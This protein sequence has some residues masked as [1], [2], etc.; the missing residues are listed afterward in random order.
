MG[1]SCHM[2]HYANEIARKD[3]EIANLRK[4]K[5]TAETS[6]RK[7]IHDKVTAQ[8]E[9]NDKIAALE[10]QVDRYAIFNANLNRSV[11]NCIFILGSNVVKPEK[12][13]IWSI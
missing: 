4:S 12:V 10:E 11:L 2:L 13:P 8:E 9:L 1:E 5:Y 6:M 7:A 3:I